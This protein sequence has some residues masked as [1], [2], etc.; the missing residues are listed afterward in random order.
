MK[1]IYWLTRLDNIRD[2]NGALL[3]I[4][5][6]SVVIF[7]AVGP[8]MAMAMDKEWSVWVS[9]FWRKCAG[10]IISIVV[11]S[12]IALIFIPTTKEML[13][14]YAVGGGI[15]YIKD[16]DV[17]KQLPDKYVQAIDTLLDEYLDETPS[18]KEE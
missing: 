12:T 18:R 15:E 16:N 2:F 14:I 7:C 3:F 6:F 8:L 13:L 17:V 9:V 11:I 4:I 5:L 1:E 10:V